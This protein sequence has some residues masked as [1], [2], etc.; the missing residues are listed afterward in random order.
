MLG[1]TKIFVRAGQG[2]GPQERKLIMAAAVDRRFAL[3][4]PGP[5]RHRRRVSRVY[6]AVDCVGGTS[7]EAH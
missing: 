3:G 7:V 4:P 6:A 2:D 1:K 5:R